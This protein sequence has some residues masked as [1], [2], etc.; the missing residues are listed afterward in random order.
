MFKRTLAAFVLAAIVPVV[1][2]SA[3]QGPPK[4]V[5]QLCIVGGVCLELP[6]PCPAPSCPEWLPWCELRPCSEWLPWCE[7]PCPGWLP[8]CERSE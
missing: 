6:W 4:C 8:W 7:L 5:R 1:P 3:S 2:L